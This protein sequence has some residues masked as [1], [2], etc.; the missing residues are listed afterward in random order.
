MK[1]ILAITLVFVMLLSLAACKKDPPIEPT[2]STTEPIVET[3]PVDTPP[4]IIPDIPTETMPPVLTDDMTGEDLRKLY[5]NFMKTY[6]WSQHNGFLA[7]TPSINFTYV[8][9]ENGYL[10]DIKRL[11]EVYEGSYVSRYTLC[12]NNN[13]YTE[14][15][16]SD[17][18]SFGF[19]LPM[20]EAPPYA[21][22]WHLFNEETTSEYVRTKL[23]DR[24][25]DIVKFETI[26]GAPAA[27]NRDYTVRDIA[28]DNI[29][30][31]TVAEDT[32][33]FAYSVEDGEYIF[34]NVFFDVEA[35][36]LTINNK[37]MEVEIMTWPEEN[38]VA[39]SIA[40]R[41]ML[42]IDRETQTAVFMEDLDRGTIVRFLT[43]EEIDFTLPKNVN[44]DIDMQD[45]E[46]LYA[47]KNYEDD[48]RRYLS[49]EDN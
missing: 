47:V 6:D 38:E 3:N 11:S 39:T 28:T 37:T 5:A 2:V 8:F 26:W 46:I 1:K 19:E 20:D 40:I 30:L 24:I 10:Q 33:A 44:P 34:E 27:G 48:V 16:M 25:Y 7:E 22:V 41:G 36:S 13:T 21:F 18:G 15:L 12:Y 31:V 32:L 9:T 49:T 29:Y 4:E 17:A 23:S 35:G 14:F 42:Y 43:N 45:S